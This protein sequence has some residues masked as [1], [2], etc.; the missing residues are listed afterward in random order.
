[1]GVDYAAIS[2]IGIRITKEQIMKLF[3]INEDEVANIAGDVK[4]NMAVLDYGD[5]NYSGD[6][7]KYC[8]VIDD[9][10]L[11]GINGI[12]KTVEDFIQFLKNNKI[13][14]KIEFICEIL[15]W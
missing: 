6:E 4:D 1:M 14:N 10:F 2:G 15:V 7:N 13:E 8:L 3:N 5:G 12:Q 11:N 9:I